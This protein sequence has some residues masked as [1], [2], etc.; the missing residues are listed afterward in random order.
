MLTISMIF[1][2]YIIEN[3]QINTGT[4]LF[5][6]TLFKQIEA[7]REREEVLSGKTPEIWIIANIH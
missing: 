2:P 1:L 5:I 4:A 6:I 7:N 3:K